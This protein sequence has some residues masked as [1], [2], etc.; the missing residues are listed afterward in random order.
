MNWPDLYERIGLYNALTVI[1]FVIYTMIAKIFKYQK[2]LENLQRSRP[3]VEFPDFCQT[4]Y[5][6]LYNYERMAKKL[7]LS[8]RSI[9]QLRKDLVL[10]PQSERK[11]KIMKCIFEVTYYL[12]QVQ[13]S[14]DIVSK[15]YPLK[16]FVK[17]LNMN[18]DELK[19]FLK[20][21]NLKN[22]LRF[23]KA[24]WSLY[25]LIHC[26]Y[27][28]FHSINELSSNYK[29]KQ[30]MKNDNWYKDM[31]KQC[32]YLDQLY[33]MTICL[34]KF[35]GLSWE[36]F[37]DQY[38][39]NENEEENE[40]ENKRKMTKKIR[41]N[42]HLNHKLKIKEEHKYNPKHNTNTNTNNKPRMFIDPSNFN[43]VE[44]STF[45]NII[46]P[47]KH[48]FLTEYDRDLKK[49][50]HQ[51]SSCFSA[52]RYVTSAPNFTL[53][54]MS[55][56]MYFPICLIRPNHARKLSMKIKSEKEIS[57][58][59]IR[60]VFNLLEISPL[61]NI[62]YWPIPNVKHNQIIYV[63]NLSL[64]NV[65]TTNNLKKDFYSTIDFPNSIR[66][67]Y[68]SN[69]PLVKHNQGKRYGS[70][71]QENKA[72]TR[73]KTI[74]F[75]AHGG[76]YIGQ[77]SRSHVPYL[78]KWVDERD[79]TVISVDY[80]NP[81]ETKYPYPLMEVIEAYK[82]VYSHSESVFGIPH[83]ELNMIMAGD[84]AGGNLITAACV[85]LIQ[86]NL[87]HILPKAVALAYPVT[88]LSQDYSLSQMLFSE[89]TFL[90]VG[91]LKLCLNSYLKD[92]NVNDKDQYVSPFYAKDQIL[93][94]FPKTLI[95]CGL[96]DPLLDNSTAFA[97]RLSHLKR[98]VTLRIYNLPHSFWSIEPFVPACGLPL[99]DVSHFIKEIENI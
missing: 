60:F 29:T 57:L 69:H 55:Y 61:Q 85:Y 36:I 5:E 4:P 48:L 44:Y 1:K 67:R 31:K 99:S 7:D 30:I 17:T 96:S 86:N 58:E 63:P 2:P 95:Q 3:D 45:L 72:K 92:T 51:M 35:L 82:W 9:N 90:T 27:Q 78:Q 81:P 12:I 87:C 40:N 26:S 24:G 91:L 71:K 22:D 97:N 50:N 70:C 83:E 84:S 89:G 15:H 64:T 94:K 66:I 34:P 53:K 56:F 54:L 25:S 68:I 16:E 49:L 10:L 79:I 20:Q 42:I 59:Q 47:R 62:A 73:T 80:T 46:E 19:T 75:H 18:D 98:D 32:F 88:N 38:P 52:S 93:E 39:D 11:E 43:T 65:K 74:L 14:Y 6:K 8:Q 21:N 77:T 33:S 13:K 76:G 41:N 23:G 37:K 28:T